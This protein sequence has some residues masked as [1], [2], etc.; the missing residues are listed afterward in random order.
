MKIMGRRLIRHQV[1][2]TAY[3]ANPKMWKI[4]SDRPLSFVVVVDNLFVKGP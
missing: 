2:T 3:L 1:N 4:K